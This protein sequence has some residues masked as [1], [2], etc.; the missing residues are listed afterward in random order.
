MDDEERYIFFVVSDFGNVTTEIRQVAKAMDAWAGAHGA[1]STILCLG[2]NFYPRGVDSVDDPAFQWAWEDVFLC[3]PGL[4]VPWHVV[5][6]NH[7]YM[8]NPFAQIAF[9]HSSKN[10]GGL[11]QMPDK[12]YNFTASV[13]SGEASFAIGFFAFDSNGCQDHVQR[14]HRNS[15]AEAASYRDVLADALASSTADWKVCNHYVV[16]FIYSPQKI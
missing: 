3:Y 15:K 5:L 14:V 13:G 10:P 1:P 9:T 16:M 8:G 7:D 11:W 4:R 2:D 6:G 12:N